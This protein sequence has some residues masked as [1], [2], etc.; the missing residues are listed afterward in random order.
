ML[1]GVF[2]FVV[3]CLCFCMSSRLYDCLLV[4]WLR[5]FC[6]WCSMVCL[7]FVFKGVRVRFFVVVYFL[8]D[9]CV[10]FAFV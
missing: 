9:L 3:A 6:V 1:D 10:L 2:V 5:L 7:F 4:L 8:C